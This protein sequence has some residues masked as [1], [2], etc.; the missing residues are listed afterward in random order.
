MAEAWA[1]PGLPALN[2]IWWPGVLTT[3]FKVPTI[4]LYCEPPPIQFI[5]QNNQGPEAVARCLAWKMLARDSV[6]YQG[7]IRQL[8]A[9]QYHQAG[10]HYQ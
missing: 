9:S 10:I 7:E 8:K 2:R 1:N 3:I 6:D 4:L 5:V